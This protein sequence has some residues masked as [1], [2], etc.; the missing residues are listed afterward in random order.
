MSPK[1]PSLYTPGKSVSVAAMGGRIAARL[2]QITIWETRFEWKIVEMVDPING[3]WFIVCVPKKIK[4]STMSDFYAKNPVERD[5]GKEDFPND[6]I[7]DIKL[8]YWICT[9]MEPWTNI[10][11]DR[12]TF[13]QPQWISCAFGGQIELWGN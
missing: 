7:L 11:M 9:S 5:D 6:D 1:L 8:G 12:S 13:D 4:G 2:Q 10:G 3:I